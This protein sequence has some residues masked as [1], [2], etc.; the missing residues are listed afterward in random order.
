VVEALNKKFFDAGAVSPYPALY[1]DTCGNITG[2]K[3][4][5]HNGFSQVWQCDCGRCTEMRVTVK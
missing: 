4:G 5:A 2:W 3:P 1:C